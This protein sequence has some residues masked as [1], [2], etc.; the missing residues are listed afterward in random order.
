MLGFYNRN[1]VCIERKFNLRSG[2]ILFDAH[3]DFYF[4]HAALGEMLFAVI[5]H[6]LNLGRNAL[7]GDVNL[8]GIKYEFQIFVKHVLSAACDKTQADR[9]GA[10]ERSAASQ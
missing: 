2:E 3:V 1:A 7:L 8:I 5:E 9:A 4:L 10:L 6:S